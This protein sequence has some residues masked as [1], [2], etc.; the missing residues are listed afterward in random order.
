MA[1]MC[2]GNLEEK[3]QSSFQSVGLGSSS[4][5]GQRKAGVLPMVKG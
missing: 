5:N 3:E 2:L 4:N 1:R